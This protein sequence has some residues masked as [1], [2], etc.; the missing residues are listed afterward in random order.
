MG[1]WGEDKE[2]V[3]RESA[4]PLLIFNSRLRYP[5]VASLFCVFYQLAVLLIIVRVEDDHERVYNSVMMAEQCGWT[6]LAPIVWVTW[7]W[8]SFV[9]APTKKKYKKAY[10]SPRSSLCFSSFSHTRKKNR[11]HFAFLP[12]CCYCCDCWARNERVYT[13]GWNLAVG[14]CGQYTPSRR[15]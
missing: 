5:I 3:V 10:A 7:V 8:N 1:V 11:E 2:F 4:W 6:P 9:G 14:H 15:K 12:Y 13:P